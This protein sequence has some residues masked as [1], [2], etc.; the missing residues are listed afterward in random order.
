MP[1]ATSKINPTRGKNSRKPKKKTAKTKQPGQHKAA[2]ATHVK[3]AC[4]ILNPFCIAARAARRPDGLAQGTMPFQVRG[5]VNVTTDT[6]GA[7]LIVIVP[8]LGRYGYATGALGSY[9]TVA[10]AWTSFPGAAFLTTNASEIRIVSMGAIFRSVASMTNCSG[11]LHKAVLTSPTVSQVIG[12][13][14]QNNVEDELTPMTSGL[15]SVWF[16][17]PLGSKAHSFRPSADATTTMSDFDWSS[18]YFEIQGGP[19]S[20][21]VGLI[22]IVV[23]VEFQLNAAGVTTTGLS[24]AVLANKPANPVALQAQN[25]VHSTLPSFVSGGVTK[26]E[27]VVTNIASKAVSNLLDMA[28]DFGLGLLG[29]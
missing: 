29:L 25:M 2:H 28:E 22:E 27:S 11:Y 7:A 19:V 17:K 12:T 23:N 8:G 18:C 16:S 1:K 6:A 4:S 20:A 26:A 14:N 21:T 13:S 5:L 9:W 3:A 10:A 24:G 15:E